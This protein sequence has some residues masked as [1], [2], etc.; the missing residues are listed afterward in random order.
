MRTQMIRSWFDFS[1][2]FL[3]IR[4][5]IKYKNFREN[6]NKRTSKIKRK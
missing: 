4:I 2:D 5:D 1:R 3:S 6:G